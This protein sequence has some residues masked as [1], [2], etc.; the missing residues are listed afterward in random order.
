MRA[1]APAPVMARLA[2]LGDC[3]REIARRKLQ[4]MLLG[5]AVISARSE[6]NAIHCRHVGLMLAN[7]KT[8]C[9]IGHE[10]AHAE[11]RLWVG[12]EAEMYLSSLPPEERRE[13]LLDPGEGPQRFI[14][15]KRRAQMLSEIAG[16]KRK[17]TH[18]A[19]V[20]MEKSCRRDHLGPADRVAAV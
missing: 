16:Q 19:R 17:Q 9:V 1:T 10:E 8:L 11:A 15:L 4:K 12:A 2:D 14:S 13:T 6:D 3:L 7:A 20:P 5:A 18:D